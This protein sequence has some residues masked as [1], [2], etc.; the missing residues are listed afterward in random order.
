MILSRFFQFRSFFVLL[1]RGSKR[2]LLVNRDLWRFVWFLLGCLRAWSRSGGLFLLLARLAW[3]RCWFQRWLRLCIGVNFFEIRLVNICI[4]VDDYFLTSLSSRHH[5]STFFCFRG[6]CRWLFVDHAV[7]LLEVSRG[8]SSFVSNSGLA[9]HLICDLCFSQHPFHICLHFLFTQLATITK[10]LLWNTRGR[11]FLPISG[12]RT[13]VLRKVVT[14]LQFR[15]HLGLIQNAI[16]VG[17]LLLFLFYWMSFDFGLRTSV[18]NN[19][20]EKHVVIQVLVF[21]VLWC[22][23][24]REEEVEDIVN[25][26]P[27]FQFKF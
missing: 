13:W 22:R 2:R 11:L 23:S 10:H 25:L 18:P 14:G 17:R 7:L 21:W 9:L 3:A 15:L 6:S 4:F 16:L 24:L 19:L 27:L 12:L 5:V 20:L 26:A 1:N 8:W